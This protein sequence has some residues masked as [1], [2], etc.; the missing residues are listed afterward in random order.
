MSLN[1][2]SSSH[3]PSQQKKVIGLEAGE[4]FS[5]RLHHSLSMCGIELLSCCCPGN[6][7]WACGQPTVKYM[8]IASQM[9]FSTFLL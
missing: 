4:L 6:E 5:L 9:I 8:Q 3:V 1:M 2:K 7:G